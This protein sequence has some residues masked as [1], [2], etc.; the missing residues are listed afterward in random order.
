[1]SSTIDLHLGGSARYQTSSNATFG[2]DP[3]Y[4]IHGYTIV[5]AFAGIESPDGKW[6]AQI[7]GRNLFN[8]YYLTAILRGG[9]TISRSTGMGA[10][11]GITLNYKY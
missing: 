4:V 11:Y 7:W 5:D 1:M 9:D 2:E 10:T 3:N 6:S 8:K